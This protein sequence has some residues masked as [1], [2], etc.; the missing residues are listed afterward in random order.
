MKTIIAVIPTFE[1]KEVGP[2]GE[3]DWGDAFSILGGH[4]ASAVVEAVLELSSEMDAAGCSAALALVGNIV[5]TA[6]A[7]NIAA[8]A[9]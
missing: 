2:E 1:P 3:L 8:G 9:M 6:I 4:I 5:N 7:E